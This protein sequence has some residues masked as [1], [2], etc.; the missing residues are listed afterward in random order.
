MN[1]FGSW[2]L[3]SKCS[4]TDVYTCEK[5]REGVVGESLS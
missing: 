3:Q 2:I 4:V 1:G 5:C